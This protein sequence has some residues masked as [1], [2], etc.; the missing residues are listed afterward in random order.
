MPP[1]RTLRPLPAC[2]IIV[3]ATVGSSSKPAILYSRPARVT[4]TTLLISQ[5]SP[6]LSS[7]RNFPDLEERIASEMPPASHSGESRSFASE[8]LACLVVANGLQSSR[9]DLQSR[10][11]KVLLV[12]ARRL[13]E[14]GGV[15]SS[16]LSCGGEVEASVELV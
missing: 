2:P 10:D 14:F 12:R 1:Y 8:R 4:D 7:N 15:Y 16:W 13:R 6:A 9:E 3:P 5:E 11:R